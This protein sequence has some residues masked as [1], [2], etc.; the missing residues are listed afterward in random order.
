[1]S[2]NGEK[3][4]R[5][6]TIDEMLARIEELRMRRA[7]NRPFTDAGLDYV[8]NFELWAAAEAEAAA[9]LNPESRQHRKLGSDS[10]VG[11]EFVWIGDDMAIR[12]SP[13]DAI[14]AADALSDVPM[15]QTSSHQPWRAV[16]AGI[17]SRW[18]P[19]RFALG[20][21]AAG[22]LALIIGGT[23]LRLVPE[24]KGTPMVASASYLQAG[25]LPIDEVQT[26][27]ATFQLTPAPEAEHRTSNVVRRDR[28]AAVEEKIKS[29]LARDGFHDVG[30]SA[31][32]EGDVY[33]AANVYNLREVRSIMRIAR[34][35]VRAVQIYFP[36]PEVRPA[37]G[38][39]YFGAYAEW[40]PDVWGA[41]VSYVTIGSPAFMAGIQPGDVI[42]EFDHRTVADAEEL[43]EAIA[44]HHPGDR[45]EVRVWRDGA[46]MFTVARLRD[47]STTEMAMR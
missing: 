12:L 3:K 9:P 43:R 13:A 7:A 6:L 32:E 19:E 46:N 4:I 29:A 2:G 42:R 18:N 31:G 37:Q 1:M 25:H 47:T 11:D 21:V 34:H 17:L 24:R 16:P 14:Q 44:A 5:Y 40:A 28:P 39:A 38:P 35:A 41:K 15:A 10:V 36:H 33:L 22:I 30:V 45:I 8:A 20:T 27:D 23:A 26:A